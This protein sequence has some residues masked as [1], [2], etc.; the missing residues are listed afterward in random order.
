VFNASRVI[1]NVSGNVES[2]IGGDTQTDVAG[3]NTHTIG[4]DSTLQV[5]GAMNS[6]AATSQ[7]QS[8]T[9]GLIAQTTITGGVLTQPGVGVGNS[10]FVMRGDLDI[11]DGTVQFT[12]VDGITHDGINI[13]KT[14]VHDEND[15][16]GPTDPPH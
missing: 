13:G 1:W 8:A 15:G 5:T 3:A 2:H 4:G 10:G 16:G 12:N 9:H 14:H 11:E 6:Q 7:H